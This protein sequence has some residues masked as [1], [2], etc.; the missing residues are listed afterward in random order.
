MHRAKYYSGHTPGKKNKLEEKYEEHLKALLYS[1]E[2]LDYK[3][4]SIKLKVGTNISW[5]TP[6][7]M[8]INKDEFVEFHEVKGY[9]LDDAKKAI[10]A[11]ALLYPGFVFKAYTERSK[12]NGGGFEEQLFG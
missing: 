8:V 5:Y 9:W 7:F 4:E 2:I 12:K 11:A 10:K 1:G 6:D 3:F